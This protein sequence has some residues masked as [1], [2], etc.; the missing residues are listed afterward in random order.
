MNVFF[1]QKSH[2][3]FS[4]LYFISATGIEKYEP[5]LDLLLNHPLLVLENFTALFMRIEVFCYMT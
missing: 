4:R 2:N 1:M 5:Q 3:Q